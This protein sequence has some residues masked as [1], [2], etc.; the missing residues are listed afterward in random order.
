MTPVC[1]KP[2]EPA[3]ETR[4]SVRAARRIAPLARLPVFMGLAGKRAIVAGGS[5]A[6]AWKAELLAAC[7]ARVIVLAVDASP[8]MRDLCQ[9]EPVA[10]TL[11]L[12]THCWKAEDLAGAAVAVADAQGDEE[13]EAFATAARRLGVPVNVIDKPAYCDF[14]FG[15][16]V[17]RSPVIVSISTDG[18]APILGQ[19]LRRRIEAMLPR[20]V[21]AWAKAAGQFRTRLVAYVPDTATRRA[22]WEQFVDR[23]FGSGDE[24]VPSLDALLQT[25]CDEQRAGS[26]TFVGAGPGDAEMLT[27]KAVRVLQS[28]DTI[29]FDPAVSDDV[30]EM[31]RREAAR[32][33]LHRRPSHSMANDGR[34]TVQLMIRLAREGRHVVRINPGTPENNRMAAAAI[35]AVKAAGVPHTIVGGIETS[36]ASARIRAFEQHGY[37]ANDGKSS[38]NPTVAAPSH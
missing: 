8:E 2:C 10:G 16:I 11:E 14:Q 30:L 3:L 12:Q 9:R 37:T 34:A 6:A 24:T 17:N 4:S 13:A 38:C 31:A 21:G 1:P 33:P 25:A 19:A 28:A 20:H 29:L 7:G 27:L 35:A 15:S 5:P 23:L 32:I 18:A 26:I 22:F 36:S